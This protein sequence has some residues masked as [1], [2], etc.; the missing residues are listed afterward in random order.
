MV[1]ARWLGLL[2]PLGLGGVAVVWNHRARSQ[3]AADLLPHVTRYEEDDWSTTRWLGVALG[4]AMVITIVFFGTVLLLMANRGIVVDGLWAISISSGALVLAGWNHIALVA[5]RARPPEPPAQ[6]P[7][8]DDDGDDDEDDTSAGALGGP[9]TAG[10]A[11]ADSDEDDLSEAALLRSMFGHVADTGRFWSFMATP[12]ALLP[13]CA[14][15]QHPVRPRDR[16]TRVV[17]LWT[18]MLARLVSLVSLQ[19]L[20]RL[21]QHPGTVGGSD[22][23]TRAWI[24]SGLLMVV[25][26]LG[27]I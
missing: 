20:P 12:A 27:F 13:P 22:W 2:V 14:P 17:D 21:A 18:H 16:H 6:R 4:D 5:M 3:H 11:P 23:I 8:F 1:V 9:D 7:G 24:L 10:D 26:L 19:L 15:A 25:A